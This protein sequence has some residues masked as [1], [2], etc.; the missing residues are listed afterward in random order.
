MKP[1]VVYYSRTGRTK[2]VA[3]IISNLLNCDTEEIIDTKKRTGPLGYLSSGR[4]AI[5]KQLTTLQNTTKTP[6]HYDLI[7]LG[8]PI[9]VNTTSTPMRT[10]IH[11]HKNHFKHVAFFCTYGGTGVKTTFDDM[12]EL[13]GKKPINTLSLKVKEIKNEEHTEKIKKF[14]Q[15]LTSFKKT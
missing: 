5:Q 1:L 3:N 11:Q 6:A 13:C 12:E 2:Q 14:V 8:T 9:W 10:Y 15:E 4:Q 7:I